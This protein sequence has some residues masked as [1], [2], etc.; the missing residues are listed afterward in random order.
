MKTDRTVGKW[1]FGQT[2]EEARESMRRVTAEARKR[3][4]ELREEYHFKR[5]LKGV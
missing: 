4:D 1:T 5:K 3:T 2:R